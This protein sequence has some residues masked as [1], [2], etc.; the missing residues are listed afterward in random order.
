MSTSSR[1]SPPGRVSFV[2]RVH[3]PYYYNDIKTL[4]VEYY[5]GKGKTMKL[6]CPREDL[7]HA[8]QIVSRSV[9]ARAGI[10][11]LAGVL[12]DLTQDR[13]ALHTTDLELSTQII[14]PVS[15]EAGRAL[16]PVRYL[17]EIVRSL[18]SD[19]VEI[20]GQDGGMR[21]EGGTARYTLRSLPA[22][23]FPQIAAGTAGKTFTIDAAEF[24]R[25]AGQVAVA[26]SR[27]ETRPVLTGVLL[28]AEGDELRLVATDS[29]RLGLRKLTVRGAGELKVIVPARAVQ[30]VMRVAAGE[31]KVTTGGPQIV[32]E[33]G[34]VVIQSRLIEGEFP[35][36]RKL[37]P[38]TLPRSAV[39]D[40]ASLI[41]ELRGA[42]VFAQDA[43]PVYIE[44][45]ASLA[46][47]SCQAQG[48]G[49]ALRTVECEFTGAPIR[50]AFN[51]QYLE[52]GVDAVDGNRVRIEL[53]DPQRAAMIHGLE[54]DGFSYLIMP[55]RVG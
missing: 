52:Q 35:A 5:P 22:E 3:R 30:E 40:K 51:P 44:L 14:L 25:A 11:A 18:R 21:I 41:E 45:E 12:L 29:Y 8:L 28:E 46:R 36:Y 23:D 20:I 53:D 47:L 10:P 42:A 27:D 43:T 7:L 24:S 1:T 54:D 13:L 49:E 37:L 6:I 19:Q 38:E 48:L 15:G 2:H 50:L 39:F 16:L 17:S 4:C 32:F 34:D 55:I 33:T 9:G 31:V 26:A